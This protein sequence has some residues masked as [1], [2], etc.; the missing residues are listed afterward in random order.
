MEN[1][2]SGQGCGGPESRIPGCCAGKRSLVSRKRGKAVKAMILR[3]IG[4]QGS[5]T[6]PMETQTGDT[7]T[8]SRME[9]EEDKGCDPRFREACQP[10]HHLTCAFAADCVP[11]SLLRRYHHFKRL[12]KG[13]FVGTLDR[14][15][16]TNAPGLWD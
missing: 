13:P 6:H 12:A 4:Q 8:G 7:T 1:V 11:A 14:A 15:M 3:A 16:P 10:A 5:W 2:G 9:S